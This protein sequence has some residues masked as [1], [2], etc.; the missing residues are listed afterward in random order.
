MDGRRSVANIVLVFGIVLTV[1]GIVDIQLSDR[2]RPHTKQQSNQSGGRGACLFTHSSS[3]HLTDSKG[4]VCSRR[5]QT[6][7]MCCPPSSPK[8][9]CS[10]CLQDGCC[11]EYERCV[12]C[13]MRPKPYDNK[14]PEQR[15]T[16]CVRVCR[17][18]SSSLIHENA[19]RS[20]RHH[21]YGGRKPGVEDNLHGGIF[22]FAQPIAR[23]EKL[24]KGLYAP[25]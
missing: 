16:D 20:S 11:R 3:T 9:S 12:S 14:R 7:S 8:Y 1:L 24:I 2:M 10:G 18:D 13:C 22:D 17:S 15:F 19:Y 6:A 4:A 21:C 5:S 25:G 23:I